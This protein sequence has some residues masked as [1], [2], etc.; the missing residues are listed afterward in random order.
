MRKALLRM[1][2]LAAAAAVGC[3][4]SQPARKPTRIDLPPSVITAGPPEDIALADKDE[5]SLFDGGTRAFAAGEYE[6]AARHFDRLA[7]VFPDATDALPALYD[8]GLSYERLRL[9]AQALE[10]FERYLAR[11]PGGTDAIDAAFH[12]ALAEHESGR[13]AAAAARLHGLSERRGLPP[14]RRAEALV[15]EAVSRIELGAR[16]EGERLLRAALALGSADPDGPVEPALAAQAEFWLGEI[17]RGYFVEVKLDPRAM[18]DKDLGAALESK[19]QFLLSAQGHYLRA[20]RKGDG[21][22]ATASGFRIG[23]LYETFHDAL[24]NAEVP[25][26]LPPGAAQVYREELNRKVRVL[27]ER[28]I[29]IYEETRRTAERVGA[30]SPYVARTD[31]ALLRLRKLLLAPAR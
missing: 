18:K 19:A 14:A 6:K 15:Q 3:A 8:A 29:R 30:R 7:E 10:R 26:G 4:P 5:A 11:V 21:E 16:P 23:G 24:V 1:V 17:Y 22:W 2:L 20:I 28:A 9:W 27:V 25:D 31:E 12:A 13:V